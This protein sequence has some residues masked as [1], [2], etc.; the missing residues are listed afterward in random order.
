M[1]LVDLKTT[2]LGEVDVPAAHRDAINAARRT[3]FHSLAPLAALHSLLNALVLTFA[4][5]GHAGMP[6]VFVW[7]YTSAVLIFIRMREARRPAGQLDPKIEDGRIV[8]YTLLSGALW[9]GM[10][11]VLIASG[12]AEHALLLGIFTA[13]MLCVGA[14]LHSSFPIASLGYSLMITAGAGLGMMLGGHSWSFNAL[15]LLAAGVIALQRFAAASHVSDIRRR[16]A[17]AAMQDAKD[18]A[19]LLLQDFEAHSSDWV[20][21]IDAHGRLESPS[22]R[23]VDASGLSCHELEGGS[24]LAL[25]VPESLHHLQEL[26]IPAAAAADSFVSFRTGRRLIPFDDRSKGARYERRDH[27]LEHVSG[28]ASARGGSP[29]GCQGGAA[30]SGDCAGAGRI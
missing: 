3:T 9:S 15:L 25:F 20:W 21:R 6:L 19:A 12:G 16:L 1:R 22:Q 24:F 14:L 11:A 30:A 13:V 17:T 26:L 8:R 2:F 4:F 10:I 29:E 28:R 18:T 5:W 23:F 7:C 27:A